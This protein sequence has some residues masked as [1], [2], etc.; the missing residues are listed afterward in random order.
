MFNASAS[1]LAASSIAYGFTINARVLPGGTGKAAEHED[2]TLVRSGV[3][4]FLRDEVHPVVKAAHIAEIMSA[5]RM[6]YADSAS[7]HHLMRGNHPVEGGFTTGFAGREYDARLRQTECLIPVSPVGRMGLQA[8]DA[9]PCRNGRP[10][11]V[12]RRRLGGS[13][14][15]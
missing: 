6:S 3:D 13:H 8:K 4:E 12:D 15:R 14:R 7:R 1:V 5:S 11:A 2:A 9:V 10:E